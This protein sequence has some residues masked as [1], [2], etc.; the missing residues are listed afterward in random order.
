[1]AAAAAMCVAA[2]GAFDAFLEIEGIP[3]EVEETAHAGWIG[4]SSYGH[5]V[6]QQVY[7]RLTPLSEAGTEPVR[8][9]A[10]RVVKPIDK[11]SPKLFLA[12]CALQRIPEVVLDLRK[13][14][15]PAEFYVVRFQDVLVTSVSPHGASGDSLPLEEV[16]FNYGKIAWTYTQTDPDGKPLSVVSESWDLKTDTDGDGIPDTYES[17][18]GLDP[19]DPADGDDDGDRD[20]LTGYEEYLSGTAADRPDSVFKVSFARD[21][22]SPAPTAEITW[23]S[24]PGR[25]YDLL[26]APD[27]NGPWTTLP[28]VQAAEDGNTTTAVVPV[29]DSA[30]FALVRVRS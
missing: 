25:S 19:S 29:P 28:A 5:D 12:C 27:M 30:V 17:A 3:G 26:V 14:G 21:L 2:Q 16:S 20:G 9:R 24:T 7:D 10:F 1:V 15:A 23:T 22:G 8:H 4:V 18:F 6:R 11:S 13:Q